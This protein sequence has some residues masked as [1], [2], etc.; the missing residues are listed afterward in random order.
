MVFNQLWF[1]DGNK[2]GL[3]SESF[4][5]LQKMCQITILSTINLKRRS[6]IVIWYIFLGWTQS[7]KR[8]E[9]KSP[10]QKKLN[11]SQ[12]NLNFLIFFQNCIK[13]EQIIHTIFSN[14]IVWF[15]LARN[16]THFLP[17][18]RPKILMSELWS[19]VSTSF[20][21]NDDRIKKHWWWWWG[22]LK[23]IVKLHFF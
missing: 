21:S 6:S 18:L 4:S 13:I 11:F 16:L 8:S 9:I 15:Q 12:I 3:I 7:E 23:R 1:K 2:G 14:R 17:N 19:T 20:F 10:L 22:V 5:I